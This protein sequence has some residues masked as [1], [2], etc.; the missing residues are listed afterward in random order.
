L[1]ENR[2]DDPKLY[3]AIGVAL[4]MQGHCE[5]AKE[6]YD[7]G[8]ALAP[9]NPSLRNNYGLLQLARG[10]LQGA[11][12]TFSALTASCQRMTVIARTALWSS[13]LLGR[14]RPR[15]PMHR[16]SMKLVCDKP[17]RFIGRCCATKRA[18]RAAARALHRR[19]PIA[20][21]LLCRTCI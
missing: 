8:L 10:D 16:L 15:W 20:A 21:N 9:D 19:S 6:T 2:K 7:Q 12:A 17:S 3:N 4:S 1:V 18:Y 14:R 13:S 11:L 5:L